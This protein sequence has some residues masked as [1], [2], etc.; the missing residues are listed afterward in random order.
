MARGRDARQ[1]NK[2]VDQV[3]GK[4]ALVLANNLTHIFSANY[5]EKIIVLFWNNIIYNNIILNKK[6]LLF[7]FE[8]ILYT[9]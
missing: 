2:G 7:Y 9:V 8:T 4:E 6:I 3:T 5:F 1:Q